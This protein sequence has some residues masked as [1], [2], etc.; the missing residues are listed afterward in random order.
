MKYILFF[1]TSLITLTAGAQLKVKSVCPPFT[2]DVLGGN[3]NKLYPKTTLGEIKKAFP[4]SSDVV[5]VPDSAHCAGIFF[6][7]EG[8][9]FYTDRNYIEIRDNFK[10][11]LIPSLL[12]ASRSSLFKL[13]GN[14]KLKDLDWD[15]FQTEYGTLVLYYKGGKI[16][17]LQISSKST[18]SL[19]LCE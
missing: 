10:G 18:E 19:K 5:N 17:K 7:E 2:V 3:V 8:L 15:A 11:K 4:C 16:N 12:G 6:K 9:Y 14:P 1:L 13:L